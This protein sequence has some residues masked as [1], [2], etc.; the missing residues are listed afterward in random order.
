MPWVTHTSLI[1]HLIDLLAAALRGHGSVI[2][3]DAPLQ[4][5][6][7]Q[8]FMKR[9]RIAEVVGE[10][11]R[12]YSGLDITVE[13]RRLT[14]FEKSAAAQKH[15]ADDKNLVSKDY[16]KIV[17]RAKDSFPLGHSGPR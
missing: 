1:K 13:N 17:D 8:A 10:V 16:Y 3:G 5:C 15:Q 9:T 12:K 4:E 7:F 6:D 11:C 2:I 14:L